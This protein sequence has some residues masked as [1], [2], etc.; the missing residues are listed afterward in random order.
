M[1]NLLIITGA[2]ASYDVIDFNSTPVNEPYRPPLTKNLFYPQV[3]S[4]DEVP[5]ETEES[6]FILK[7]LEN[8]PRA[9][10]IGYEFRLHFGEGDKEQ[11]LEQYLLELKENPSF[12]K[13]SQY[14]SI[15]LYIKDLFNTISHEY[16]PAKGYGLPSNYQALINEISKSNYK[17]AIWLNLN[18][19]L[20]ADFAIRASTNNDLSNL[21]EYMNIE[22]QDGLKIKYVKPHGSVNWFKRLDCSYFSTPISEHL[23]SKYPNRL[24]RNFENRLSKEIY[25]EKEWRERFRKDPISFPFPAVTAPIGKYDFVCPEHIRSIKK[26]LQKIDSILCI[27]FNA[28]DVDILTL[29]KESIQQIKKLKIISGGFK[30]TD[31]SGKK[32]LARIVKLYSQIK[33]SEEDF[34]FNGGFTEFIKRG[35]KDWIENY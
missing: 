29:I 5:S 33:G 31:D 16:L 10:Q 4:P 30:E 21:D 12:L 8:H 3:P 23:I 27:G 14:W 17:Q 25:T 34:V 15:P 22:T 32:V 2:G 35:I 6:G 20:F 13:K 18:Y 9:N 11:N 26:D 28:L 24:P 7:C 19:D 1:E